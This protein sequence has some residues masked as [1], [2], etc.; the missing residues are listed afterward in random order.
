MKFAWSIPRVGTIPKVETIVRLYLT[1]PPS[2][3]AL[4]L[5]ETT[6]KVE[7]IYRIYLPNSPSQ[8]ALFARENS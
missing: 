6:L 7:P 4:F 8:L 3:L 2:Q 5:Y 1:S